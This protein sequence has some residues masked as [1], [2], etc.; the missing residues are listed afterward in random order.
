MTPHQQ[1]ITSHLPHL[2]EYG[3]CYRT[4]IAMLLDRS[5]IMVPHFAQIAI[6][7]YGSDD[8]MLP[9]H[10]ARDWLR[11]EGYRLVHI[12][13]HANVKEYVLDW[14][15]PDVPYILLGASPS[16]AKDYGHCVVAVG[17]LQTLCDPQNLGTDNLKP[18]EDN[19]QFFYW[20]EFIFKQDRL[21]VPA[22]D[23]ERIR[24]LHSAY[25]VNDEHKP[26]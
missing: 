9:T 13:F 12:P 22:I 16:G 7:Q 2:G 25:G 6:E 17:N 21:D 10:I 23:A 3:D 19:G 4:C 18:Y 15:G 5:P 26:V 11:S 14:F 8:G 24:K 20:I 1:L